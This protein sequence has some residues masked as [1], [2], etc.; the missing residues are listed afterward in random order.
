MIRP[1]DRWFDLGTG[2]YVTGAACT[3]M[4]LAAVQVLRVVRKLV[5]K[6][7]DRH[8][9]KKHNAAPQDSKAEDRQAQ[10]DEAPQHAA[11]VDLSRAGHYS[12]LDPFNCLLWLLVLIYILSGLIMGWVSALLR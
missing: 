2:L 11:A 9:S 4:T 8:A 7:G 10:D 5:S 1:R 12:A 6:G 3:V